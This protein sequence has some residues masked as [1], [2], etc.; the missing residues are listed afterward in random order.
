MYLYTYM[1]VCAYKTILIEFARAQV[2][3][4]RLWADSEGASHT[5]QLCAH[6]EPGWTPALGHGKNQGF[7][8]N[9]L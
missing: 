2:Q 5:H 3:S 9:T 6:S 7:T 1:Y 4:D 8:I